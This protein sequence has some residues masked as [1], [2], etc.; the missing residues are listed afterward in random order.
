M[1]DAWNE[2]TQVN[3]GH[4][5][6]TAIKYASR[7]VRSGVIMRSVLLFVTDFK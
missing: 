3:D 5:E 2:V 4:Y 7:D 6:R 1:N